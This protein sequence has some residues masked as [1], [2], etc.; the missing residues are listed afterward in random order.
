MQRDWICYTSH[1]HSC[2]HVGLLQVWSDRRGWG[3]ATS[4]LF[5]AAVSRIHPENSVMRCIACLSS[6]VTLERQPDSPHCASAACRFDR[7]RRGLERS[8]VEISCPLHC[9]GHAR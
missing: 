2:G 6:M 3:Y 4:A 9:G 7:S 8:D 5:V 1:C